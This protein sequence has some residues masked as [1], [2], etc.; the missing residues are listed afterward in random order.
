MYKIIYKNKVIVKYAEENKKKI[1][2]SA[3]NEMYYKDSG[4]FVLKTPP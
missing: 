2:F 3:F 4:V 1:I